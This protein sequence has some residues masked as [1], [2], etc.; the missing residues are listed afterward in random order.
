MS[1]FQVAAL[2]I[3]VLILVPLP[4]VWLIG[5]LFPNGYTQAHTRRISEFF[6]QEWKRVLLCGVVIVVVFVIAPDNAL[7]VTLLGAAI[8]LGRF[9][10]VSRNM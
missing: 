7:Q 10:A 1:G 2:V 8:L 9:I 3:T 5:M 4:L 6:R